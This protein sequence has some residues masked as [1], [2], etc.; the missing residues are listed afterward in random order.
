[1]RMPIQH[2]NWDVNSQRIPGS[3]RLNLK[4]KYT[5]YRTC[6]ATCFSLCIPW[7]DIIWK[8]WMLPIGKS[9]LKS[10]GTKLRSALSAAFAPS[11][12]ATSVVCLDM[13]GHL[14]VHF[15][16]RSGYVVT[17]IEPQ[18]QPMEVLPMVLPIQAANQGE[19]RWLWQRVTSIVTVQVVGWWRL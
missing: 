15:H 10:W 7:G 17:T 8:V 2:P 14:R 5:A 11:P 18:S 19:V 6:T 3:E 1:M 9:H 4:L 16:W 13:D 12:A